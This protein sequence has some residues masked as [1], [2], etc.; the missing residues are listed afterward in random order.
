MRCFV[1]DI[2]LAAELPEQTKLEE[3]FGGVP[4]GLDEELWPTCADCGKHQSLLAQ[5]VHDDTRLNLG[6]EGRV[7]LVFQCNHSPGM[8]ET[9]T[10]GSGANACRARCWMSDG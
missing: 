4:W 8:C 6:R 1:P 9:E 7:L 3:K 10:G 2:R 5:L